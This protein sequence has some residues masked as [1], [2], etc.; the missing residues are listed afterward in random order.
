MRGQIEIG[1]GPP[2][3]REVPREDVGTETVAAIADVPFNESD[4]GVTVQVE[5]GGAPA[6]DRLRDPEKPCVPAKLR[7]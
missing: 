6:H 3:G 5:A 1:P 2:F 7:L 4:E